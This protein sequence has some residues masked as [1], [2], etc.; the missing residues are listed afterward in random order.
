MLVYCRRKT[1]QR[2]AI[3]WER[4]MQQ[5]VERN[6]PRNDKYLLPV[7]RRCN[8]KERSQY[9]HHQRRIN[10][11]LHAIS[12]M[13]GLQQPLTMYVAR[14]SWASIAHSLDTPVGVISQGMGHDSE[15]T[16]HISERA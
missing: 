12:E 16:T 15:K 14:H 2:L 8:G 9:R 5:I 10:E 7:I 4:Q 1:G 3:R 13:L 6:P 11:E